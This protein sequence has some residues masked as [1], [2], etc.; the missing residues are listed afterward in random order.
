MLAPR[1][2][3]QVRVY[4]QVGSSEDIY[5][6]QDF[7]FH[8]VIENDNQP[9]R[10]DLS[11]LKEF[12]PRSAGNRDLSQSTI[13][14]TNGRT[15]RE[16]IKRFVMSYV[17][18]SKREGQVTIPSVKVE[19]GGTVYKTD[20][21]Q[22][23]VL[24]PGQTDK[25]E[26]RV[27]LSEKQCYVGQ[28]IILN[29]KFLVYAQVENFRFDIPALNGADFYIEDP[30]VSDPSAQAFSLT[31]GV[32]IIAS[33]SRVLVGEREAVLLEFDK[34]LIPKR[35]GLINIAPS[36]VSADVVVGKVKSDSL[37]DNFFGGQKQYKRF[38]VPSQP[39]KLNVLPLPQEKKPTGFYGLLGRYTI[40]ASVEPTNVNVGDPITMVIK[41]GGNKFLKPVVWPDLEAIPEFAKNFKIPAQKSSPVVQNGFK[42]FTQTI[43]ANNDKVLRIPPIPLS[44]FD[45]QKGRYVTAHSDPIELK[46]APTKV[47]TGADLEGRE[48]VAINKEVEAIK[49]GISANYES[50]D[51]LVNMGFSLSTAAFSSAMSFVWIVPLLLL[52]GSLCAKPFVHVTPEKLAAKTRRS[53]LS[54]AVR[55]LHNAASAGSEQKHDLLIAAMTGYIGDRFEKVAG[56]LTPD[57]CCLL[58]A[59]STGQRDLA[60]NFKSIIEQ[61]QAAR[62]ASMEINIDRKKIAEV[63][64][65]IKN[66]EK[67][68][69]K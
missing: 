8:I 13:N 26:L 31:N 58:I 7:T 53:A 2:L 62:F 14:I 38:M 54:K 33:R 11:P 18:I 29:V 48:F 55:A 68:I 56:S 44:F 32:K 37:V 20:P 6:G 24:K 10:V 28:P 47:L 4:S 3:C 15:T 39:L 40:S 52:I 67:N 1:A 34:I 49:K 66:I 35:P 65:L 36:T 16:T 50:Q 25:L 41:V 69:K 46:V 17:L 22:I 63:I 27:S 5:V 45:P 21:V 12:N 42:V 60:D 23:N 57:D 51:A 30:D 19:V 59:D 64:G 61:C 43:R 9:G